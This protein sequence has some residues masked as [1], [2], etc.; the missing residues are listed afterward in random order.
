MKRGVRGS[1]TGGA[2]T[3]GWGG[4]RDTGDRRT[5]GPAQP[6]MVE[7]EH[8]LDDPRGVGRAV[9]PPPTGPDDP[10]EVGPYRVLGRLGAGGMGTVYLAESPAGA[11]VAIKVIRPELAGDV[12]FLD[13]FRREVG[14]ARRVAG[15]CTAQVLDANLDGTAPYL[16]TEYV[17]GVRLDLV[18]ERDG[19][20]AASNLEGLA[21]GVAAALAGI[22]AAE[23]VHRDLKP[24]NVLL[25]YFGPRVIDFGIARALDDASTAIT[26]VGTVM[27]TPAWMAPEQFGNAPVTTA[28]DIF[29]WGGL[30]AYAGTGRLAFGR[31]PVEVLAYRIVHQP[32]D[33]DGLAEPLR[34]LVELAMAKDP[35][36]RPSARDLLAE[37]LDDPSDPG[38]VRSEVTKVLQRTW[39]K[40]P[41]RTDPAERRPSGR[42][43]AEP[44]AAGSTTPARVA[45]SQRPRGRSCRR[46][47]SLLLPC[48]HPGGRGTRAPVGS[49]PGPS[50]AGRPGQRRHDQSAG[51]P[52]RR[53]QGRQAGL[54]G[55]NRP[56]QPAGRPVRRRGR[57]PGRSR[58]GRRAGRPGPSR[59]G[60]P[61]RRVRRGRR[62]GRPGRS[63]HGRRAGARRRRSG[64]RC[65][66]RRGSGVCWWPLPSSCSACLPRS[67][68]VTTGATAA[69]RTGRTART[70]SAARRSRGRRP[71][72]ARGRAARGTSRYGTGSSSSA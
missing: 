47:R 1:C 44:A 30:V 69:G 18:V 62:A 21:V 54:P 8:P 31:G 34:P 72:A 14:A 19:P 48:H 59:A 28:A 41:V 26:R 2:I 63:R 11:R 50:R 46:H 20:L 4:L 33:L 29:A 16:V 32:P 71:R 67:T 45:S 13:R 39:V 35:A 57:R 49:P 65:L 51:R 55:R 66:G 61:G 43:A 9:D 68:T 37:L 53:W 52:G 3:R 7:S 58:L 40:E 22:H 64:G 24:G 56:D 70:R 36:R 6:I 17:D 38:T 12:A 27:G 42:P 25:S 60:R 15:F 23:V 10:V 5:A